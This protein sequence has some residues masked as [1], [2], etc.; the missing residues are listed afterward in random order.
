[1]AR[2]TQRLLGDA[3]VA[4]HAAAALMV[5]ALVTLLQVLRLDP[6]VPLADAH[7]YGSIALDL[8]RYHTFTDGSE[9]SPWPQPEPP[10]GMF[11]AP[12]Y[13]SLVAGVLAMDLDSADRLACMLEHRARAV[14]AGCDLDLGLLV[15]VQAALATISA[16]LV[17]VAG[18][19]VC[20]SL[21]CAWLAMLLALATGEY[22]LYAVQ[23]LTENLMFPLFTGFAIAAVLAWRRPTV[24]RWLAAGLLVGLA[25]LV[26]PS[27]AYLFYASVVFAFVGLVVRGRGRVGRTALMT[28]MLA[29]GYG[30]VVAPWVTRNVM[31]LGVADITAGYGGHELALRLSYNAMTWQ[32]WLVAFVYWLP[33]FGDSLAATLFDPDLYERLAFDHLDGYYRIGQT[34]YRKTLAAAGRPEAHVAYLVQTFMLAEPIKHVMVT[35]ALLWRGLWVAK[36]WGLVAFVCFVPMAVVAVRRR[37]SEAIVFVLP[38][39]FMAGFHAFVSVSVV[40]YNLILIPC[41]AI[42]MAWAML[43][44]AR[45]VRFLLSKVS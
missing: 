26:R 42:A 32:E 7:G 21:A 6:V 39:W 4:A 40:R 5:A 12:L 37:W 45:A 13:P 15:S 24:V 33:G 35:F 1:M 34:F 44:L 43:L 36:E 27:F 31:L 3:P 2:L 18:S 14:E 17:F 25:A 9:L 19:L 30:I 20:G 28:S 8:H 41:F 23:I 38:P 10:P 22:A 11:V 29:L 16:F